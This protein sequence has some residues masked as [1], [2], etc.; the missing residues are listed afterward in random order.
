[1]PLWF[2]VGNVDNGELD[3]IL[4]FGESIVYPPVV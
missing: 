3:F 1:M 2:W 4:F